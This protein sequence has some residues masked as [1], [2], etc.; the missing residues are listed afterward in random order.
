MNQRGFTI[1]ELL[2]SIT[3]FVFLTTVT[4]FA[5]RGAG[6]ANSIRANGSVFATAMRRAQ[7]LATTQSAVKVCS[8]YATN[9][10]SC[11]SD[12]ACAPQ[13]CED[14]VPATGYGVAVTSA[15]ATSF[16]MFASLDASPAYSA[17][18]DILVDQGT[19]TLTDKTRIT[20]AGSVTFPIQRG[21]ASFVPA[22]GNDGNNV[23]HFCVGHPNF[24][25]IFRKV[26]VNGVTGLIDDTSAQ[27]CT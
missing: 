7:T 23:Q 22:N 8:D 6:F 2:I 19:F 14:V 3:I 12:A 17:A 11:S 24:T 9:P 20:N 10:R 1:V 25:N 26:I 15:N 16:L 18:S 4:V 5:F 13:T 27:T 21:T